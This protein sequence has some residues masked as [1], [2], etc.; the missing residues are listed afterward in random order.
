MAGMI[1]IINFAEWW[2]RGEHIANLPMYVILS[3]FF[4]YG[5]FRI[6]LVWMDYLRISRPF[7]VP[8]PRDNLRV[9][10]FTTSAPGEPLSMFEKTFEALNNITYPHNTYLLDGTNDPA[11]KA[12]AVKYVIKWLDMTD[13]PGAK[14]GKVNEALKRTNEDFILILDP[15]HIAFP[16]ML[17]QILGFFEDEK[18]GFVQVAQ[19]YYNHYRS[20]TARGAAEQTY[21][22]YGPA[23]MGLYGYG[24]AVAIG[25]NCT[26]RRKALES[27]GGHAQGLAEDLLTSIRLHAKGWKSVYNPVIVNRG[28]VPEDLS[29]FFKQQLKWARGT[30][31]IL[32]D[33]LPKL[34]RRLSFWQRIAYLSIST[35]Y[36]NGTAMLFFIMLPLFYFLTGIIP[37]KMTLIEFIIYGTPVLVIATI[38]YAYIQKFLCHPETER[39]FHWR[40]MVL[41]FSSW[42]VYF[43]GL[44]LALANKKIPYLPTAK[45]ALTGSVTTFVRPLVLYIIIFLI[46]VT[47]VYIQRRYYV[48]ESQL[49]FTAE[50]VWGMLGFAF[51]AFIQSVIGIFAAL[52]TIWLKD[53]E[54]WRKINVSDI[55]NGLFP[56]TGKTKKYEDIKI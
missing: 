41:K 34:F 30:F 36:F 38:I 51:I 56:K 53:D 6:I 39:K 23:Q 44:L 52:E 10:I 13:V 43:Y 47:A 25:A 20:F 19:G 45:K 50:R 27:I 14:A 37:G 31:E 16:N 11:F 54:P 46:T 18:V 26:F 24:S 9:A 55:N 8:A 42:P 33:E 32:F 29:S 22:F 49:A 35:Y 48:P 3:F 4:W 28:L 21:T 40:G 5:M 12:L 17:D 15:D 2:F 7:Q 1:S